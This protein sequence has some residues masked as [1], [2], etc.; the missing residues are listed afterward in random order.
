MYH[1]EKTL[2]THTTTGDTMRHHT[3]VHRRPTHV[4]DILDNLLNPPPPPPSWSIVTNPDPAAKAKLHINR[5]EFDLATT[6]TPDPDD[7]V[8][9][10]AD[11]LA[12][13]LGITRGRALTYCDIGT[14]LTRMPRTR[15]A[16][17][18]GA[19]NIDLLRILADL[20]CTLDDTHRHTVDTELAALLTN[21]SLK[22]VLR[23]LDTLGLEMNIKIKSMN[24]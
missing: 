10:T 2:S 16:L 15:N 6:C 1:G 9:R 8:Y 20:T 4:I 17:A 12:R 3:F 22:I 23:V 5:H 24:L 18:C 21:P 14:M 19:F 11:H 7:N 13:T